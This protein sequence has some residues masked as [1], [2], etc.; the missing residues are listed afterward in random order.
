MLAVLELLLRDLFK[1]IRLHSSTSGARNFQ[2]YSCMVQ[3]ETIFPGV[4]G[5]MPS[6]DVNI[7][8]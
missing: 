6:V 4:C 5:I 2:D 1:I 3:W 7:L 8:R